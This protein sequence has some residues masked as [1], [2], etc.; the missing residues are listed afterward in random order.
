MKS[1]MTR[2]EED[3]RQIDQFERLRH[4]VDDVLAKFGCP[5][6]LSKKGDYTVHG[7]YSGHP[8]VVVFI[9][10]LEMLR[11]AVVNELQQVVKDFLGW[12]IEIAVA[13]RGHYDDWPN[14]GLYIRPHEIIDGLQRQYFPKEFQKIEYVGARP[15]TAYD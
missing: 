9:G 3:R 8:Q 12:E 11:P 14:M 13:V 5:D 4:R 2:T 10:K 7:D 1:K 15:G 6:T